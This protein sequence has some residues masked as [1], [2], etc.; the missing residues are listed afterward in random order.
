M[1]LVGFLHDGLTKQ[2]AVLTSNENLFEIEKNAC[3]LRA[4]LI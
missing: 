1:R 4:V 3:I 2:A